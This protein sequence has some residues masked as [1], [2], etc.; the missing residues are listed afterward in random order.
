MENEEIQTGTKKT[1]FEWHSVKELL[2]SW[3]KQYKLLVILGSVFLLLVMFYG[4][5][6]YIRKEIVK[7]MNFA[8]PKIDVGKDNDKNSKK[9][10]DG[11]MLAYVKQGVEDE[12]IEG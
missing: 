12:K 3:F 6:K 2:L 1:S 8:M 7:N 9:T 5:S 11:E 10:S 4:V